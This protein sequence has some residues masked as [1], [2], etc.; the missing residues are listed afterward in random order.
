MTED[1]KKRQ[2]QRFLSLLGNPNED[3]LRSVAVE[4]VTWTF[5]GTSPISGEAHG[6]ADV[7]E[8]A[9]TIAA[10]G[11]CVEV[12]GAVHGLSG[13]AM[14]LHNTALR[15]DR[16][17][18]EQVAAVLFLPRRQSQPPRHVPVRRGDGGSVLRLSKP[19]QGSTSQS[20]R[21]A[22]RPPTPNT[23]F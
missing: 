21:S 11:V 16:V 10:H 13:V 15:N 2:A 9:T 14:T 18:D 6:I 12:I 8:R 7:M 23:M 17:L 4:D 19:D 22:K 20:D 1:E 3:V 5:P